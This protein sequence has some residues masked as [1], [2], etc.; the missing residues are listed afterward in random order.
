L[1]EGH[2]IYNYV[3]LNH[4]A[5]CSCVG[6]GMLFVGTLEGSV[7]RWDLKGWQEYTSIEYIPGGL[8]APPPVMVMDGHC[9]AIR[10]M[11]YVD[12]VLYTGSLDGT[13]CEWD[14][15]S[16]EKMRTFVLPDLHAVV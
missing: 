16:G 11:T 1:E 2:P 4:W 5:W 3:D 6:D 15:R 13:C 12:G 8:D 14:A 9:N 10:S 7:V